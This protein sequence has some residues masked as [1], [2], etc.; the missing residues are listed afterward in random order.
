[1][2]AEDSPHHRPRDVTTGDQRT[3]PAAVRKRARE[4]RALIEHHRQRYYEN[5]APEISDAD[6]DALERDLQ[7]LER[8]HPELRS[9]DSPTQRVGGK[10]G[11]EFEEYAHHVPMLS[12]DNAYDESEFLEFDARLKR[13]LDRE[14][15]EYFAELKI[16]GL[17]LALHYRDGEL[18]RAVTRGD[19]TR[20]EVVTHAVSQIR[21]VPRRLR[22]SVPFLEVRAEIYMPRDEFVRLNSLR[23]EEGQAPFANPRNAAAGTIRLLDAK[24]RA[25]RRLDAFMYQ[26]ATVENKVPT[27]QAAAMEFLASL[28]L[29]VNEHVQVCENAAAAVDYWKHWVNARHDLPYETDGV[30]IK[31]NA[32]ELQRDAGATAK[33][34]RWAIAVKFPQQQARTR[35][36]DIE[37][38]VGRTGALTPVARLEP[39]SLDGST[40]S[41]A[42]LHNKE[43]VERKDVRV[44]DLVI[45]QKA[46]GIIPQVVVVLPEGRRQGAQRFRMPQACP[47]CGSPVFR[48][49]DEVIL[50]CT[51]VSCPAQRAESLSHFSSRGA[52]NIEGLGDS[53]IAQLLDRELVKNFAD[54][55]QLNHETLAG[56]KRM[57]AQ[58]ATNLLDFL[59]RSRSNPLH[60]LIYALGIRHVGGGTARILAQRFGSLLALGQ[61]TLEELTAL[62]DIGPVV[63]ASVRAFFDN[64]ENVQILQRLSAAG[65]DP[66]QETD[67]A[68]SEDLLLAGKTFVLTGT[69]PSLSRQQARQRIEAL[70]GKVTGSVSK[71]TDYL[72]AGNEPGSKLDKALELAVTVLESEEFLQLL[73]TEADTD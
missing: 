43:E 41:S 58:S 8:Q 30:V 31:A 52:M 40:V 39:V 48:S 9:D 18:E 10:P 14:Q 69:L 49:E 36:L 38:Q 51:G 46:G 45:V 6:Y 21:S 26:L 54:L 28:G 33:A 59:E 23:E 62:R 34:P 16:D 11:K 7:Q 2:G 47:S 44:G 63:A 71:K 35:V 4:L 3:A 20:G 73:S 68:N 70:G 15:I 72:V 65:V 24:Q 55:Y 27:T 66:V 12:L 57:G 25:G 64:A 56:L 29:P 50:R 22:R 13:A 17:S 60:H 67:E 32:L 42:S 53:L 1:M 19:G 61:A 5:D 37:I